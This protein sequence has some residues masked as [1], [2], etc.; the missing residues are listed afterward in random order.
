M[1]ETVKEAKRQSVHIDVHRKVCEMDWICTFLLLRGTNGFIS[2]DLT[3]KKAKNIENTAF[4][5]SLFN[6][7]H[8]RDRKFYNEFKSMG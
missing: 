6:Y 8:G 7:N 3:R 2:R 5:V 4:P 1:F